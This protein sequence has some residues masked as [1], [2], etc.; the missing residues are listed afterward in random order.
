MSLKLFKICLVCVA[1][2]C[3]SSDFSVFELKHI[4]YNFQTQYL[5]KW[6]GYSSFDNSWEDEE[7]LT[8]DLVR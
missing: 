4:V 2:T 3:F 8:V 7:N 6:L 5:V 1:V